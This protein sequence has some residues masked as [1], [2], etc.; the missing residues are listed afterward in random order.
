MF[1]KTNSEE[2]FSSD[3]YLSYDDAWHVCREFFRRLSQDFPPL[4]ESGAVIPG[5][6]SPANATATA[7]PQ[8]DNPFTLFN[9]NSSYGLNSL[10]SS[11]AVELVRE[12]RDGYSYIG[13]YLYV[14]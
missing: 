13:V 7:R 4:S 9:T 11:A 12:S 2:P 5:G 8:Q 14:L 10:V 3:M 6:S 1:I